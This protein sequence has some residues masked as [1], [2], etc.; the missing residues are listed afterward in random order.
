MLGINAFRAIKADFLRYYRYMRKNWPIYIIMCMLTLMWSCKDEVYS[1]SSSDLLSFSTDTLRLDTVFCNTPTPTK[2]FWVYNRTGKNIRLSTVRLERGNQSGFRVNVDGI[3]LGPTTGYQTNEVEIRQ[4]DSIRVFVELTAL[5]NG[6]S[7]YKTIND[8]ILFTT[9]GGAQQKVSLTACSWDAILLTNP[10]I[11]RDTTLTGEKPIVISGSMEVDSAATLTINA[12]T[13]LYFHDDSHLNVHGRLL[14]DGEP[15][16][17]VVLRGYRLDRMFDYL[18]YDNV[19]GQWGGVHFYESS[20]ENQMDYT[21]LHSAYTGINIDSCSVEKMKLKMNAST[22]HN[23]Q[24]YGISNKGS[25]IELRNC[26]ITNT[27]NDCLL[28]EG[29]VTLLNNCTLAQFYPFDSA[30]GVA[31]RFTNRLPMQ[32]LCYNT[33]VTGYADDEVMG[34]HADTLKTFLYEFHN[35][36]LRTPR[37][38]TADSVRFV[39]VSFE[40]VKDTLTTGKKHFAK[41]DTKNLRYDFRLDSISPAIDVAD[42]LTA[43][44]L[45]RLG[46][47]RD[48]KPDIGAYEYRK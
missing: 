43:M 44:P 1:E 32:L 8:N 23:C 41:I 30:R 46:L 16:R 42:P 35:C 6:G 17:E 27:L 45:D 26:Q 24:G 14:C 9:E 5:N 20:Y 4:T 12:G 36:I 13:T 22:V 40:D 34:E 3:Y 19:S 11:R 29:G 21:D 10:V 31:L 38:T 7:D 47:P 15:G 18:P 28:S 48:D 37:I 2:T 25:W 39:N 33:L